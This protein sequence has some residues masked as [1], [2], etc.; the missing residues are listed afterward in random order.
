[1]E[2]FEVKISY[3]KW[4]DEKGKDVRINESYVIEAV[5]YTD[6][7]V[8]TN[9]IIKDNALSDVKIKSM[10]S[11]VYDDIFTSLDYKA[12]DGNKWYRVKILLVVDE[13]KKVKNLI[14]V[15]EKSITDSLALLEE[16]MKGIVADWDSVAVTETDIYEVVKNV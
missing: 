9:R 8:I 14:L 15:R 11:V 10:K 2:K 16:K 7:E 6:A 1:M 4:D 13:G 5:N 12:E 3:K